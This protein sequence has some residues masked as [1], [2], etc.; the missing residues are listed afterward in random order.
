MKDLDNTI[1]I[2]NA[3]IEER[4]Q[5]IISQATGPEARPKDISYLPHENKTWEI[6][7]TALRPVWDSSVADEVLE[8]REA[9]QLPID[10]VPQLNEVSE[11]LRSLSGFNYHSVGGLVDIRQFFGGLANGSF[12][13]TQYIRRPE[14]P[15]YTPEPDI[16]H[17]VIGHGTCL[18]DPQLARLH[19][20]AGEAVTRVTTDRARKFVADVWWFSGEFGVVQQNE[21]IKAY[22]A[23][24]LSSLGE[25]KAVSK[26]TDIRPLNYP[27]NG[28]YTIPF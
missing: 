20:L 12:L 2:D 21:G 26:V 27:G 8:A 1:P 9:L 19:M 23:G 25:L 4:K 22:G 16:I 5:H 13:S 14:T 18:A 17:E 7:S 24:I 11:R 15:L 10:Q 3:I 28:H 6:V